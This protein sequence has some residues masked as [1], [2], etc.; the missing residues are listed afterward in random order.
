MWQVQAVRAFRDNYIWCL[1]D[2]A[3]AVVVDP[4]DA[5]PVIEYLTRGDL[6][7]VAI[8]NTH[9]HADHVGGNAEL[10]RSFSVPVYGPRSE[11]IATVT[12]RV[13]EGDVTEI[14]E[15]GIKLSVIDIPGHT[16]GHVAY[17]G[18]NIL[19]CGDTLFGCGCGKLFEGSAQQMHASL[20]K[21][22]ALPG[23]TKVFCGHEYTLANIA[24]AKKVEPDNRDL[25]QREARD[26]EAIAAARPTL[27]STIAMERATN[28]FLRCAERAVIEAAA[29]HAGRAMSDAV[30][31]F[32]EIRKWKDNFRIDD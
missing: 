4:G 23:E 13:S 15:L 3:R 11:A 9:H 8:L 10:L 29:R 22:A 1:R 32:A 31:V 26:R 12:E 5:A 20:S 16:R 21:L 2:D 19:F 17:Y 6:D 30:S 7:L 28:P 18:A 27:P 24:F 14:S 25:L